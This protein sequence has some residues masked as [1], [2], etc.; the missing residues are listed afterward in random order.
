MATKISKPVRREAFAPKW[1]NLI[2]TMD[3]AG[4]SIREKGRRTTYGPVPFGVIMM[5]GAKMKAVEA[6]REKAA[7]KAERKA[8]RGPRGIRK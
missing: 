4:I 2:I 1:G 6:A 8:L 7:R 5:Q 3:A